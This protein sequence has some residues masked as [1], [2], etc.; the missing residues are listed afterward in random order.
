MRI[1]RCFILVALLAVAVPAALQAACSPPVSKI[2][3]NELLFKASSGGVEFVEL[4]GPAGRSLDCFSLVGWNGGS[5]DKCDAY[6]EVALDGYDVSASGYFLAASGDGLS[7]SL[8][9]SK[10]DYQNGADAVLLVYDDGA[11]SEIV[12][13]IAYGGE[14]PACE[15]S[16][17]EGDPAPGTDYDQSLSRCPNKQD[18]GQNEHDF[19][20]TTATTPGWA[21]TCAEPDPPCDEVYGLVINEVYYD[22]SSDPDDVPVAFIELNG[23]AG[24]D[25]RCYALQPINGSGCQEG[26]LIALEGSVAASGLFTVAAA[27]GLP[28]NM[29]AAGADLQNGPDGVKLVYQHDY[30]GL[31]VV[32]AL[33]YDQPTEP[34][35]AG[36]GA[37]APDAPKGTS[38]A[39]LPDGSDSGD[40]AADFQVCDTPTPGVANTCGG[41]AT[42]GSCAEAHQLLIN[43]AL[44]RAVSDEQPEFIELVG[45]PG[46]NLS[47]YTLRA[48][49][50]NGCE[51]Y[52]ELRLSG[53]M[54]A[55]GFLVIAD[56][57]VLD[58]ADLADSIGDLQDGPDGLEL[59]KDVTGAQPVVIDALAYLAADEPFPC[60]AGE[61]TPAL[62]PERGQS[63]IRA[64]DAHD[65][66]DNATDFEACDFPSPGAPNVCSMEGC[67]TPNIGLVINE[68]LYR[69]DEGQ[70]EFVEIRGTPNLVLDCYELSAINGNGCQPYRR[71]FLSGILPADGYLVLARSDALPQTDIV[72]SGAGL[73]K[74]P[75]ALSLS[76][77]HS[78]D[79]PQLIDLVVYNGDMGACGLSEGAPAPDTPTGYSLARVPDGVD[80]GDNQ[81]DLQACDRPSPGAAN[82]CSP[83]PCMDA[84]PPQVVINEVLVAANTGSGRVPYLELKG[85]PGADLSCLRLQ[86]INGKDCAA[87][88]VLDFEDLDDPTMPADGYWLMSSEEGLAAADH[89]SSKAN[90]QDGP[91]GVELVYRHARDGA[92][93]L[94]S[95][96]YGAALDECGVGEGA[97]APE[98]GKD[99]SLARMPD[100]ADTGDNA[101]D[102]V[103]CSA[104]SPGAA[105]ACPACVG[106]GCGGGDPTVT[107]PS[108]SSCAVSWRGPAHAAWAWLLLLAMIALR[109]R[110]RAM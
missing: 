5:G 44:I 87:Y 105:N 63:L 37:P 76:Y 55:D 62:R 66:G 42:T 28:A 65:T 12:D 102:F 18:T 53:A 40:N 25:L 98:P 7:A 83:P 92:L 85:P 80:C 90:Y 60:D 1:A 64:P 59:L 17:L 88:Q 2:V 67:T 99:S 11:S 21:N 61:G 6:Q 34:C 56:S 33:F 29:V 49:N 45:D 57:G 81:R 4:A 14:L 103:V 52:R 10:V 31:I 100:G 47:C 39:R 19:Q 95:M 84:A 70:S 93:L 20:V 68:L 86:G 22:V 94:D 89:V 32:D 72:V 110:R 27:E 74:G 43:E 36:E 51:A 75:D 96:A 69:P 91:D 13:L 3:I 104:P 38:L 97:P 30:A 24:V 50:G 101:V 15:A 71:S 58:A 107:R 54:P 16:A 48:V 79:G 73:Q 9:S 109:A 78:V 41:G 46:M 108:G 23:P 77:H 82:D 26:D 35:A 106:A 8:V